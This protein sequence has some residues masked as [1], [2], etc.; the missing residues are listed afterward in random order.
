MPP[1]PALSAP[2]RAEPAEP[3]EYQNGQKRVT[4]GQN[5]QLGVPEPSIS[6]VW[7][8]GRGQEARWEAMA[9]QKVPT[10][11]QNAH[12][13]RPRTPKRIRNDAK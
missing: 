5:E 7:L 8:R 10:R 12:K 11:S 2:E 13:A 3:A 9:A 1:L 6:M 4:V